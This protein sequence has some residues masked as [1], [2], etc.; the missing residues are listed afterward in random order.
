MADDRLDPDRA[1]PPF[2]PA[3]FLGVDLDVEKRPDGTVLLRSRHAL[4]PYEANIPAAF[5]DVCTRHPTQPALR[6]RAAPGE[7]W[8]TISYGELKGRVEAFGQ[9]L[10]DQNI[11]PGRSVMLLAANTPAFAVALFGCYATGTPV[12]PVSVQYGALGG[13]FGRLKH[14]VD[15]TEPAVVVAE[16]S[17]LLKAALETLD[18]A[19]ATIVTADPSR[20]SI[21]ATSLASVLATAPTEAVSR[22]IAA[23]D[24]DTVAAMMLTSGST[25]MPKVVGL[26]LDN[27]AANSAQCF[28]TIGREAGW[29]EAM[30]DWLPW[31][32]AAGAF[33]LRT[34]LLNGGVLYIDNGKPAPGL[35]EETLRNLREIPVSFFN[36]VPLG[37]ALLADALEADPELRRT[38]FSRLR[39]MLYGG[40]GLSQPVH[41][42]LQAMAAAETGHRIRLTTGYGSTETVSAFMLIHFETDEV[43][44]GLPSPGTVV[45]M[46]PCGGDRYE[47]RVKGPNVTRGYLKNPART[48][49]VFDD[50][51]FY[52]MGDMARFHDP[53]DPAHGLVFAGRTADEFKLSSGVWVHGGALR[54]ALLAALAPWVTDLVL[55][56]DDRPFLTALL[57]PSARAR[58][59]EAAAVRDAI[60]KAL[61]RFNAAQGG[62]SGRVLR[63]LLMEA[64]ASANAHE[65]SDKGT[66]NRRTIIDRR[67][68][69]L[70]RL[71][72]DQPPTDVIL[73][74]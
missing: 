16:D 4:E 17:A 55:C 2:R 5:A 64:P 60:A 39:V 66:L 9:W 45:K 34:T 37:Y 57:W 21:P 3:G 13:D 43:G 15:L 67:S 53:A 72:A 31:H 18:W 73:A 7:D 52:S 71:Y 38:F 48:A 47:L 25:G 14:V 74:G 63:A 51:G 22:S 46:V 50:E 26:T 10:L 36:N 35:F 44:I 70:E 49:E 33:V 8:T 23:L 61:G 59:G 12:C 28:Q 69:D 30:L 27:L 40:A 6:F 32:H 56:D 24:T 54:E 1:R 65:V 11:P 29:R 62:S 42:R 41:D 19:G 58:E 20:L 68:A